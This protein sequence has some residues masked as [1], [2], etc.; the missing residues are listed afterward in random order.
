M[1]NLRGRWWVEHTQIHTALKK[2]TK[3]SI[4]LANLEEF[5]VISIFYKPKIP[6]VDMKV[7]VYPK[8]RKNK[9]WEK[10]DSPI[11]MRI[12]T[13]NTFKCKGKLQ[14]TFKKIK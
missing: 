6:T 9:V 4:I 2:G 8:F 13:F 1:P 5:L 14:K 7:Q 10:V 12:G 11:S 3:I